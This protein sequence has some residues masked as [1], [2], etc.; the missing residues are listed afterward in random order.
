MNFKP[1]ITYTRLKELG[2]I[3]EDCQNY[4]NDVMWVTL[5]TAEEFIEATSDELPRC[6]EAPGSIIVFACD[7]GGNPLCWDTRRVQDGEYEVC[8]VYH[9]TDIPLAPSFPWFLLREFVLMLEDHLRL[10]EKY[11]EKILEHL[12]ILESVVTP[13]QFRIAKEAL[14]GSRDRQ[15]VSDFL[16]TYFP[17]RYHW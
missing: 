5:T 3:K 4:W 7:A 6:H 2:H 16:R 13:D 12:S 11:E 15:Q 14:G 17:P 10:G 8:Q 1:P 9:H